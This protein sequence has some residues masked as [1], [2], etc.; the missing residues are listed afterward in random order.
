[1]WQSGINSLARFRGLDAGDAGGGEH[2]ALGNLVA[3][4]EREGRRQQYDLAAG[5]GDAELFRLPGDIHHARRAV[6]GHMGQD[7]GRVRILV[8]SIHDLYPPM[9]T[10]L[11]FGW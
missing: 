1:M 6:G 4:D 9:A 2:V 10:I 7:G 8:C 5:G 11:R 3:F